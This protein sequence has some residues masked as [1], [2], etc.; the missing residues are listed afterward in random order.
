ME[1]DAAVENVWGWVK[2]LIG[3]PPSFGEMVGPMTPAYR[4][5]SEERGLNEYQE[6]AP[7]EVDV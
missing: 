5:A 1:I 3:A 2:N 7:D 4:K 6:F